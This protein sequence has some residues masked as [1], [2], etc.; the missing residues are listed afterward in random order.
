MIAARHYL[1]LVRLVIFRKAD[2]GLHP[3]FSQS[4]GMGFLVDDE[5]PKS[6]DSCL[7]RNDG[8]GL[9]FKSGVVCVGSVFPGG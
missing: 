5:E 8:L 6:L 4:G 7:R 2:A 3:L 1:F 9:S